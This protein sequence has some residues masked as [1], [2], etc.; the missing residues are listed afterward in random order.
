MRLAPSKGET[1][2]NDRSILL[3]EEERFSIVA[4][5]FLFNGKAN[6]QSEAIY[7]RRY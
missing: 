3:T 6:H 4:F 1:G 7:E 5:G 2:T